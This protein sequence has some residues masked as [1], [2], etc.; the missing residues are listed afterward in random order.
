MLQAVST[1]MR[2]AFCALVQPRLDQRASTATCCAYDDYSACEVLVVRRL[3]WN[4]PTS[5]TTSP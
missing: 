3:G 1:A 5:D 2:L 4:E